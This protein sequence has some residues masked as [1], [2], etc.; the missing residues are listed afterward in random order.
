MPPGLIKFRMEILI[1]RNTEICK[2]IDVISK[3]F[4]CRVASKMFVSESGPTF[5]RGVALNLLSRK[6]NDLIYEEF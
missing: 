1:F 4:S 6:V 2:T 3:L 5:S